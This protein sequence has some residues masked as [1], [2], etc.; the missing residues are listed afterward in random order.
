MSLVAGISN[1]LPVVA[2]KCGWA[3]YTETPFSAEQLAALQYQHPFCNRTGK[4]FPAE[5]VTS[6]LGSL[7]LTLIDS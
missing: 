1:L 2:E 4:A 7:T 5:F 3:N 6:D